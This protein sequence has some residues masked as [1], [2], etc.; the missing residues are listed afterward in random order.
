MDWNTDFSKL[1][2]KQYPILKDLYI[3]I[4]KAKEDRLKDFQAILKTY[5]YGSNSLMFN[6]PTNVKLDAEI[7]SFDLKDMEEEQDS[8]AAAMFNVLSY[9]WDEITRDKTQWKRLY[10]DEA[11]VLADPDNPRAMK[12]LFNIYKRIR[13]Y[14]GGC[15]AATQH[16]ADF[17]SAVEG[18]RN[19][20]K[21]IIGNSQTKLLLSMQSSDIKDLEDHN[22][23]RLSS[24]EKELLET[25][26]QGVGLFIVGKKRVEIEIDYTKKELELIDPNSMKCCMVKVL[27][28]VIKRL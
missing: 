8:Q 5:V 24:K 17:L 20:G 19:Y 11:H 10:V 27:L 14:R 6:G 7:I 9:L 12:F 18:K 23:V 4:D 3:K 16:I 21:A 22:I 1:N 28:K 15:T 13:K 25:D 26:A 2:S